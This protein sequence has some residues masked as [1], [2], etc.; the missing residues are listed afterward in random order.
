MFCALLVHSKVTVAFATDLSLAAV[1]ALQLSRCGDALFEEVAAHV[2]RYPLF[3]LSNE[4]CEDIWYLQKL[5]NTKWQIPKRFGIC[6][7]TKDQ[8][9]FFRSRRNKVRTPVANQKRDFRTPLNR[10]RLDLHLVVRTP[11]LRLPSPARGAP[12]APAA[13]RGP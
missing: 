7:Y 8:K 13:R 4:P 2:P 3:L 12:A 9:F 10:Q 11:V 1:R 6:V 5:V